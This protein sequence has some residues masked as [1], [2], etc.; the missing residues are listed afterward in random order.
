MCD[1]IGETKMLLQILLISLLVAACTKIGLLSAMV[2]QMNPLK[3]FLFSA[4]HF[5]GAVIFG[6]MLLNDANPFLGIIPDVIF[7]VLFYTSVTLSALSFGT[8]VGNMVE[9]N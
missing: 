6:V 9:N 3:T 1:K 5:I 4:V 8:G 2:F 7:R